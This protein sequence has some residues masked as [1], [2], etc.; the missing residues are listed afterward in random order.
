MIHTEIVPLG[1]SKIDFIGKN[2][3]FLHLTNERTVL[4][5]LD[6]FQPIAD[7]TPEQREEFEIIDD[8]YLSF[9]ALDEVYSLKELIGIE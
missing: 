3:M 7:L 5:P 8:Q 6:K 1:I 2:V 9:L 4:V